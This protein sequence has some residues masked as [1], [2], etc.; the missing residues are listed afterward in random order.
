MEEVVP[1]ES[2]VEET[3]EEENEDEMDALKALVAELQEVIKAKDEEIAAFKEQKEAEP[4][5]EQFKKISKADTKT[6][7]AL[8]FFRD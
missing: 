8:K 1:D 6:N 2:E 3:M 5:E 7:K 4:I